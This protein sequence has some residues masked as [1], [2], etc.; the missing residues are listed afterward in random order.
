MNIFDVIVI[1]ALVWSAISGFSKGFV[2][3]VFSLAALVLGVFIAYKLSHFVAGFI[4]DS[5]S[6]DPAF[7][8]VIAFAITF[9]GVWVLIYMAGK[10]AHQIVQVVMMGLI[11]RILGVAFALLKV[12]LVLG[13]LLVI[14]EN[15]NAGIKILPQE[16]IEKSVTYKPLKK[17]SNLIFPYLNFG[18]NS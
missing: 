12:T 13:I 3:Q 10:I 7:T 6:T 1:A 11:N 2:V 8:S 5:L 16:T 4:S 9:V 18:K 17:A 15:L 14:F